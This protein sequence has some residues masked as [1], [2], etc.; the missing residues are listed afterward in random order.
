MPLTK[1]A[2]LDARGD[3]QSGRLSITYGSRRLTHRCAGLLDI[4]GDAAGGDTLR[5]LLGEFQDAYA[6]ARPHLRRGVAPGLQHKVEGRRQLRLWRK[7]QSAKRQMVGGEGGGA[8]EGRPQ[9]V[10]RAS[11]LE[12]KKEAKK[13]KREAA[14]ANG[15][16]GHA[17]QSS[18]S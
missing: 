7:A 8:S 18:A 3:I 11:K 1:A 9:K 5:A 4:E 15:N 2:L 16:A 10:K 6:A 13:R 14:W 12:T 17:D